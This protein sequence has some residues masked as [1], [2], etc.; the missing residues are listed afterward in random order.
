MEDTNFIAAS[1]TTVVNADRNRQLDKNHRLF[2]PGLGAN[3]KHSRDIACSRPPHLNRTTEVVLG[4]KIAVESTVSNYQ[5]FDV[6]DRVKQATDI[7]DLVG[8]L[9]P[10]TRKGKVYV[11]HCPWHDDSRPSFQ[12]DPNRQSF[13]CWPCGIRGDVFEFIKRWDGV[14]F[15]EALKMLAERANIE[16]RTRQKPVVKGSADDKLML[17]KAMQ[18]AEEEY[19][20][21]LL[22]SEAAAPVR[23]YLIERGVTQDSIET[24]KVGFSPLSWSWL[25]DRAR[26]TPFSPKIL[27]ACDLIVS[28]NRG[29]FYD[30]FRGRVLFPI[31]D[32]LDRPIAIGG[33][34]VP[35]LY[36]PDEEVPPA[37]YVNSRETKLYSK[38]K[39]LYALNLCRGHLQKSDSKNLIVVEGYTDVIAAWQAGLRNVVAACG[40]A[41]NENHLRLIKRFAESITLVL[42]GDDAGQ[43]RTNEMLDLFIANDIDLRILS[44]PEGLDPFD[45][46]MKNGGQPFE[47]MCT[48]APDAI[49]HKIISE[50][51]GIDL[52][53][54]THRANLALEN[55]LKTLARTPVAMLN[56]SAAK[57]M[58]YDQLLMRLARQFQVTPEQ[59]KQRLVEIRS[60]IRPISKTQENPG[61][62]E[63]ID[64]NKLDRHETEL[65]QLLIQEPDLLDTTIET[66]V[67]DEFAPGVMQDLYRVIEDFYHDGKEVGYE[68]LSLEIEDPRLRAVVDYLYDEAIDKKQA[69]E[70][71]KN[72]F[73]EDLSQQMESVIDKFL[74]RR[75]A[76]GFQAKIS[77]LHGGQLDADEEAKALMEL[78]QK[79]QQVQRNKKT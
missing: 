17:F 52:V 74:S 12:V 23:E 43:K 20:Q 44:L 3:K 35:T 77:Q 1:H 32:T 8:N 26:Q 67:P 7:V 55:I 18:W 42:D 41:I 70:N 69:A 46:L 72:E 28:N 61:Q 13:V 15:F 5:D 40:T 58:R 53:H 38:S 56:L 59:V 73:Y 68:Q 14:E 11:G 36:G 30:R 76:S 16:L 66:V 71:S 49:A 25:T 60:A 39:T 29:G 51:Q 22:N 6:K 62:V 19:H 27:E 24:F 34:V 64:Y 65:V 45:Y 47:E 78:F 2:W 21:C 33:R 75:E 54:D 48:A 57:K 10:L 63:R 79:K 4:S 50:T 9:I 37:K 31:R